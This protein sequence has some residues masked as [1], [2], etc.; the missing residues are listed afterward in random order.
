VA[1][2]KQKFYTV[3]EGHQTGVFDSW[4]ACKKQVQGYENAKYKSF[5]SEEEASEA[6]RSNYWEF[7]KKEN[8]AKSPVSGSQAYITDSIAVDAAC[9]G[10][11]GLMEYQ[12]VY[13][14]TGQRMFHQGP[15]PQGTNNIGEFLAIVHA[16][17]WMKQSKIDLPL[18]TDSVNAMLWVKNKKCKTKLESTPVNAPIFDLISR[19]ERW[20]QTN[21]YTTRIIKWETKLW[22]EIPADFGRK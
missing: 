10:N 1:K 3:W 20:L 11:P 22:G 14:K 8:K 17:A 7:V 18:Y 15:M 12:G 6:Y 16:L 21:T 13:V 19:A 2:A 9:S 4:E 5:S